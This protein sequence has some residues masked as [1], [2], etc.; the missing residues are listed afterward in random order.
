MALS[1]R[2]SSCKNSKSRSRKSGKFKEFHSHALHHPVG[3]FGLLEN[4]PNLS[5]PRAD[6]ALSLG[7]AGAG[8]RSLRV[9]RGGALWSKHSGSETAAQTSLALNVVCFPVP[10]SRHRSL[11]L[12]LARL[13]SFAR[14]ANRSGRYSRDRR[15]HLLWR[16]SRTGADALWSATNLGIHRVASVESRRPVYGTDSRWPFRRTPRYP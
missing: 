6:G 4:C 11:G 16:N 12:S 1:R 2:R 13:V 7:D 8:W 5:S 3:F 10:G 14:D 9:G 15:N